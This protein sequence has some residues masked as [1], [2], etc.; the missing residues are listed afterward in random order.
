MLARV[1][2]EVS[3]YRVFAVLAARVCLLGMLE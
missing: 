1:Q 3:H 2:E